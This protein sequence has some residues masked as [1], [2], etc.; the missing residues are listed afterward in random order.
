MQRRSKHGSKTYP[1][2]LPNKQVP[3]HIPRI[4]LFLNR[5]ILDFFIKMWYNLIKLNIQDKTKFSPTLARGL[6]IYTG[7]VFEFYDKDLRLTCSLGGGGRYNGL[8]SQLG[9][10]ETAC[11]GFASGMGR[12]VKALELEDVKLPIVDDIDLFLM[13]VNDEEK[14]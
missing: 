9:G 5:L 11:I 1:Y 14:K 3:F 7:T 10:P 6:S 8:C 4:F 2:N 13:Y 12:V